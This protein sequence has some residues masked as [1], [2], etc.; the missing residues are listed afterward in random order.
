MTGSISITIE[1]TT[2]SKYF[3]IA[4]YPV[5][6]TPLQM[7]AIYNSSHILSFRKLIQPNTP[8][9]SSLENSQ[10]CPEKMIYANRNTDAREKIKNMN[11]NKSIFGLRFFA[12]TRYI[13]TVIL[14]TNARKFP[15]MTPEPMVSSSSPIDED[16][17][18]AIA[19]I[20][21]P[22][23]PTRV[24]KPSRAAILI[25]TTNFDRIMIKDARFERMNAFTSEVYS[26]ATANDVFM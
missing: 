11:K 16:S 1:T 7:T 4:T 25:P 13:A 8:T 5:V 3:I 23:S 26:R 17:D 20:T 24:P 18:G 21:A 2:G 12:E 9:S 15:I 14:D 6:P 19:Q 22:A 10:G